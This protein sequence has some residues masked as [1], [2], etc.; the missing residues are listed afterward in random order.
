MTMQA[1]DL[2]KVAINGGV[3]PYDLVAAPIEIAQELLRCSPTDA[4][5]CTQPGA[6]PTAQKQADPATGATLP[7]GPGAARDRRQRRRAFSRSTRNRRCSASGCRGRPRFRC[8]ENR[9]QTPVNLPGPQ[10]PARDAVRSTTNTTASYNQRCSRAES[11]SLAETAPAFALAAAC[12][13]L[14]ARRSIARKLPKL[15]S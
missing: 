1:L 8:H 10:P 12:R 7:P 9:A 5:R 15:I 13:A 14:S 6:L 3:L 2:I 4:P 11:T